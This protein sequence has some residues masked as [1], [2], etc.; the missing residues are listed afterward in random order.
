[1]RKLLLLWRRLKRLQIKKSNLKT[2]TLLGFKQTGRGDYNEFKKRIGKLEKII[3]INDNFFMDYYM[4]Q[5][6]YKC[7]SS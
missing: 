6:I 3:E 2:V 1:M 7:V 5:L 4:K